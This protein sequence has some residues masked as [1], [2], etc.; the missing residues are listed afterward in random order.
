MIK[1]LTFKFILSL[2]LTSL[3][4]FALNAA[5]VKTP[6][7]QC[8][9]KYEA[10]KAKSP[11][12]PVFRGIHHEAKDCTQKVMNKELDKILLPLKKN[13]PAK[14]KTA[15][16]EQAKFNTF[17]RE[18]EASWNKYYEKCCSTCGLEESSED[19]MALY[20]WRSNN[21]DENNIEKWKSQVSPPD[22]K[23][24]CD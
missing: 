21:F 23:D 20:Q 9:D 3:M 6:F 16:A 13:N 22:L 8:L 2:L 4:A 15:M 12:T 11:P 19:L 5:T 10:E 18:V 17:A 14:F 24:G 1:N 7:S